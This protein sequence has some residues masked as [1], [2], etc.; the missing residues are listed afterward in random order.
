MTRTIWLAVVCLVV[1]GAIALGKA[2]KT[3]AT[4][5]THETPVDSA[6]VDT[7]PTQEPLIKADRLQIT[8]V[9][10]E[11]PTEAASQPIEPIIPD[12]QDSVSKEAIIVGRHWHDPS[13]TNYAT[14]KSKQFTR[15]VTAKKGRSA[16]DLRSGQADRAKPVAQAKPCNRIGLADFLRSLNLSPACDS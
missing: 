10:Q 8:P 9:Q 15:T 7:G 6:T 12:I 14:A 3:P 5:T 11:A 13:D 1:L 2:Y 16:A 4:P